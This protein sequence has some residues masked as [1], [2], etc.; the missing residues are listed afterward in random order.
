MDSLESWLEFRRGEHW[1]PPTGRRCYHCGGECSGDV[2]EKV[3]GIEE[4]V[5]DEPDKCP[6]LS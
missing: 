1:E 5:C 4:V 3:E 2:T 6:A